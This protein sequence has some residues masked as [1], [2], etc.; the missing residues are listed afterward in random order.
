VTVEIMSE[1]AGCRLTLTQESIPAAARAGTE[2]GWLK[3]FDSLA[4]VAG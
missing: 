4:E 3:M 2:E 1:G